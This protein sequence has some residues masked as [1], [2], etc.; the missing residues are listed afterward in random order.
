MI[1]LDDLLF[2]KPSFEPFYASILSLTL[3]EKQ[4]TSRKFL[5][6]ATTSSLFASDLWYAL[7]SPPSPQ[8]LIL[9]PPSSSY[10]PWYSASL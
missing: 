10:I 5:K 9:L 6:A 4:R 1:S 2:P 3:C 7:P 8:L